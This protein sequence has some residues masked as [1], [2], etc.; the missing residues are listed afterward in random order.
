MIKLPKRPK[1]PSTDFAEFHGLIYGREKIG[2]TTFLASFPDALFL[3]TEPGSKGLSI[4]EIPITSW[5]DFLQSIKALED[6]PGRFKTVVIDT[7]DL[8]YDYC[9]DDVVR[10]LGIEYPGETSDGKKDYG[11][12]W[13][14]IEKEFRHGLIRIA[15]A[16]RGLWMTSHYKSDRFSSKSGQGFDRIYP[17]MKDQARRV[18]EALVDFIWFAEHV[19]GPEGPLR[20][21]YCQGD[22]GLTAGSRPL[23]ETVIPPLLE[24]IEK[25]GY[26]RTVKVLEG[27][28]RALDPSALDS[29]KETASAAERTLSRMKRKEKRDEH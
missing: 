14:L 21:L 27:K 15:N 4:Y 5:S 10:K 25:G 26:E 19:R 24:L 12:S 17:S 11:K 9:K 6:E 7:V 8:L 29:S 2:K 1:R 13:S 18:V 16:G 22:E 28:V 20:V 3:S 23:G